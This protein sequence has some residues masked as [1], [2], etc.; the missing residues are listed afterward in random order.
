MRGHLRR[1]VEDL[2]PDV[3]RDIMVET[4]REQCSNSVEYLSRSR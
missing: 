1:V 4:G 3:L 2:L